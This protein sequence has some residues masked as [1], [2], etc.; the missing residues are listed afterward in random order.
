MPKTLQG[1]QWNKIHIAAG[2]VM[3]V[4]IILQIVAMAIPEWVTVEAVSSKSSVDG[5]GR[6]TIT[7][8]LFRGDKQVCCFG[9]WL[10]TSGQMYCSST[11]RLSVSDDQPCTSSKEGSENILCPYGNCRHISSA[12]IATR[13]FS[14]ISL[15][16]SVLFIGVN[17]IRKPMVVTVV[18]GVV[19]LFL[20]LSLIIWAAG[21]RDRISDE[22]LTFIVTITNRNGLYIYIAGVL[23]GVFAFA[24]SCLALWMVRKSDE[25][26]RRAAALDATHAL[27][28][29]PPYPKD[30]QDLHGYSPAGRANHTVVAATVNPIATHFP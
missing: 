25:A 16:L 5:I 19:M 1:K 22:W 15:I 21:C 11:S 14:I 6:T 12:I 4:S 20:F 23:C 18:G 29:I 2:V 13:A 3:C 8:G 24:G 17:F 10:F 30:I 27:H 28:G 26:A 9:S 7:A